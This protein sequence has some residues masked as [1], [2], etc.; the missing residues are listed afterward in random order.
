[1]TMIKILKHT[2]LICTSVMLMSCGGNKAE[3][4]KAMGPEE[5]AVAFCRSV[6]GGEFENA[7]E[8]CDTAAMKGYIDAKAEAWSRISEQDSSA[9]AIAANML[10]EAE[11]IIDDV[12]KEGDERHVFCTIGFEGN[13][14]GKVLIM[15]KEE[16]EWRVKT[17]ADRP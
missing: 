15:K 2:A 16:G 12:I 1:M 7:M 17:I 13:T 5:V 4:K 10:S 3:E 6:A 8:L 11:V 14:K 9:F